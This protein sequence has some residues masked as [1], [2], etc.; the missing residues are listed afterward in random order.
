M[1]WFTWPCAIMIAAGLLAI[2][3]YGATVAFEGQSLGHFL[4]L[5]S[6]AKKVYEITN[7]D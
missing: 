6:P 2:W 1:V 4:A 3:V 5:K 7:G